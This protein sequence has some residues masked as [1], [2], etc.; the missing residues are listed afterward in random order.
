[1]IFMINYD[2]RK[3]GRNYEPLY[4]AIK[5]LGR[6]VH[7]LQSLWFVSSDATV[8]SLRDYLSKHVDSNDMLLVVAVTRPMA[9]FNIRKEDWTLLEASVR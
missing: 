1:M 4:A 2:L 5:A 9:G 3:P 6:F 8:G 7:P